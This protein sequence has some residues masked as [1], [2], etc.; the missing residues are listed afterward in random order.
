MP[1]PPNRNMS[2]P[3]KRAKVRKKP[4]VFVETP[5][6]KVPDERRNTALDVR[7]E[8]AD[9]RGARSDLSLIHDA[10]RSGRIVLHQ[11]PE[12]YVTSFAKTIYAR[13]E[14]AN[15]RNDDD[16]VDRFGKLLNLIE[17]ENRK[18]LEAIDKMQRLDDGRP[19]S[20]I[21][22]PSEELLAKINRIW[23][24]GRERKRVANTAPQPGPL[25]R[26]MADAAN[27]ANQPEATE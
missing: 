22:K 27:D 19:T 13:F 7:D 17:Q 12:E 14:R 11:F 25:D 6:P 26:I 16:F 15:K 18:K 21:E 8:E 9:R 5:D 4:P 3:E 24:A 1:R 20:I 10:L 23:T 2:T